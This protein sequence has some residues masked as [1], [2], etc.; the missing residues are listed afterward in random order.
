MKAKKIAGL[1]LASV[2]VLTGC[3]SST[4]VKKDGKYVVASTKNTNI[5]ADDIY[6]DFISTTTG[7]NATFSFVL[8][9]IIDKYFPVDD[10]MEEYADE[11]IDNIKS[12]YKSS[13]GDDYE[14]S[15]NS[16][17]SQSGYDDLDAYRK[18]LL[19]SLQYSAMVKKYVQ[20]NF[21]KIF[22]DYYKT[23]KPHYISIIKVSVSDF[24]NITDD[25]SSKLKEVKALLKTDKSFGDIASSYS[26]DSDSASSN[27]SLGLVDTTS[28]L[29]STYGDAVESEA[30]SLKSGET[31]GQIT[32]SDGYYFI[33]CTSTK[34]AT[35]K[36]ELK[37]VDLNSP[38]L[39]YDDYIIYDAFETYDLKYEDD[40]IKQMIEDFLKDAR[41]SE[42]DS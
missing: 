32:G 16:A 37:N 38:L 34:K 3:S 1:L 40:D 2:L 39:T 27:G 6:N 21:D 19:K 30:L 41:E 8:Q 28:D 33:K 23:A 22:E 25:E 11:A 10:D 18:S 15:L 31:S 20:N 12:Q 5:F 35:M 29:A 7:K 13:Y 9:K 26:D 14:E 42:S 24:D 17:L 36:K 4:T